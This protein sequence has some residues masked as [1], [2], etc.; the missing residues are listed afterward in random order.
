MSAPVEAE[1]EYC[2]VVLPCGAPIDPVLP[3]G[4]VYDGSY[5]RQGDGSPSTRV[6]DGEDGELIDVLHW[7]DGTP[8]AFQLVTYM[9][10]QIVR[11]TVD[12]GAPPL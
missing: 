6:V 9:R 7:D 3:G 4:W 10:P 12:S 5:I 1:V 8:T 11:N 2:A